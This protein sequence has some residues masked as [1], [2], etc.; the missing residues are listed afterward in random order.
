M[1]IAISGTHCS[2]KSTL[3]EDFLAAH[4]GYLHEPE[5]YEWLDDALAAEPSAD[6]FYRQLEISVDRLRG[7]PRGANVIAERSPVDFL[8]YLLALVDCGRGGRDCEQL[9]SA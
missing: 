8:A 7:H 1:R 2:G 9:A 6:D 3:I 5:P 4:P